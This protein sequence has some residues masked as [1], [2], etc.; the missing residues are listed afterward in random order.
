MK[1]A[2]KEGYYRINPA[3]DVK[4]KSNPNKKLKEHLES[5]EYI[6]L[7]KTPCTNN[8]VKKLL[9]FA[10]IPPFDG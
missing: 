4:T 3:E 1:A 7:I 9:F 2:T 6:K 10:V 8:E 5:D